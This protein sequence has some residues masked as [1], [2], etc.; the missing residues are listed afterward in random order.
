[1]K[2]RMLP[3]VFEIK[4]RSAVG[5]IE[6]VALGPVTITYED[7][8]VQG[9]SYEVQING[10]PVKGTP[11]D[12][13]PIVEAH[14][15]AC[16]ADESQTDPWEGWKVKPGQWVR[17]GD[18]EVFQVRE[19]LQKNHLLMAKAHS[20]GLHKDQVDANFKVASVTILTPEE[21]EAHQRAQMYPVAMPGDVVVKKNGGRFAVNKCNE[22]SS[23]VFIDCLKCYTQDEIKDKLDSEEWTLLIPGR[24]DK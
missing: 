15:N 10:W 24:R 23:N 5:K 1:M 6:K 9:E 12:W 13:L 21:V 17:W 7:A 18:G 2:I 20:V 3:F 22:D 14:N 11:N 4:A 8:S 16:F 19:S